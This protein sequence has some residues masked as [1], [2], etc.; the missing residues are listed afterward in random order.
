MGLATA[1]KVIS[2]RKFLSPEQTQV[3]QLAR[4]LTT[5]DLTALGVG[6]TLG[7][8]VYVLA[9]QVARNTAGPAVILSF[10][11]AA[12]ASLFAGLCYAEFGARAPRAGSAYIYTYVCIGEFVA[13]VIGWNL[14]LEYV[15][16]SASVARGLSS[17]LDTMINDTMRNTFI[18]IAPINVSFL[19]EYFDFFAFGISVLLAIALAFGMKESSMMNNV[20]TLI[21]IGVVVFTV[22][23]GST[24]ADTS[25]WDIQPN[26]TNTTADV[27]EGGFFPFG[28]EGM[29]KGAATCFYGFIGFD[30]IATTGEEVKN[31][32]R[33]IPISIIVSLF[34]I[35]LSYFGISTVVTLMVPY[36]AQ[37][38]NE[39]IPHAFEVVGYDWAKWVVSIGAIF[40]LC[41]SLFG[42][43]FPLPRIIYA[44]A[45]D[46][47]IFKFLGKVSDRF[48]AP[49]TGTILSGLLTGVMAGLF[50][51]NQLVNMMSIGT[52]MAYTIV[53]ASVLLLRYTDSRMNTNTADSDMSESPNPS[54][55]TGGDVFL[56][57]FNCKRNNT[58]T[59][60]S[61]RVASVLVFLYCIFCLLIGLSAIYLGTPCLDGEIW[62]ITLTS[63]AV[64]LAVIS[65][66]LL[67][68]QPKSRAELSFKVPFVPLIPALSILVNIYL[69]LTLDPMTWIRFGVWMAVGFSVYGLYGLPNSYRNYRDYERLD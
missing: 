36:Y 10:L 39:S 19:A 47:L 58:P 27:G 5:L 15:I 56:Q 66:I 54:D 37:D 44:M 50:D 17:Y 21:N 45:S 48:G 7:V 31:P 4:V 34:I 43:M 62:A 53:A 52:L 8:G 42:A 13:F 29:I 40:G 25:N 51:V 41:A 49:V 3:T 69:M 22:I 60:V 65:I 61:E 14:I 67:C 9:G 35:F 38:I 59:V 28:V 46:S 2:R 6:S 11:I 68:F 24:K 32:K 1:W 16:G 55:F 57:L 20:V 12:I 30:C 64:G 23:V 63:T 26:A 18:D 33:A